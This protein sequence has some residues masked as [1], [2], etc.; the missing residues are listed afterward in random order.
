M[1]AEI[2]KQWDCQK[3]VSE[4]FGIAKTTVAYRIN[5]KVILKDHNNKEFVLIR[6]KDF[7][8]K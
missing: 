2:I 5:N 3:K 1:V 7:E 4:E 6:A 8:K